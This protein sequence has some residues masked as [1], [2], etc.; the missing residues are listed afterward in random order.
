M[1]LI[2]MSVKFYQKQVFLY[3][4]C[5]LL[6]FIDQLSKVWAQI[7]L[8]AQNLMPIPTVIFTLAYNKGVAFS[9]FGDEGELGRWLLVAIASCVLVGIAYLMF[10]IKDSD[11]LLR[12]MALILIA[13]GTFGNLLDRIR[14]GAVVD[15]ITLVY[16]QLHWPTIF[17]V[18]D[19]YI[20]LGAVLLIVDT[21]MAPSES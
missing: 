1:E 2:L 21:F 11:N 12:K 10:K 3:G 6:V 7:T 20:T 15:F 14:Y 19:M 9:L 8:A 13:G 5:F 16:G 4:L 17:N 18:A